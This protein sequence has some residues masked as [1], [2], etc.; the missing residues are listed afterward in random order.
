MKIKE[1]TPRTFRALTNRL[2]E[3]L[4]KEELP[5]A[6]CLVSR[7]GKVQY[8]NKIGW[9]DLE[10]KIPIEFNDIFQI[11]SMTKPIIAI[12]ILSL[13][14]EKKCTLDDPICNYLPEFSSMKI[15][16][17]VNKETG[18]LELI[19]NPIPITIKH[20]LTHT[21]GLSYG[22]YP[23]MVPV[24]KLYEDKF[25]SLGDNSLLALPD[26]ILGGKFGKNLADFSK[27]L[28]SL[29][30]IAESGKMWW[31]S[32]S[33]DLLGHLVE[34]I[35]GIP[36]D[37]FLKTRIFNKLGMIDT[38]FYVPSD[39]WSRL[40]KSYFNDE[41]EHLIES[42]GFLA[43]KK[44]PSFLCGGGGLFSTLEDYL[45]FC[46]MILNG[47]ELNGT[48]VVF[49][50]SINLMLSDHLPGGRRFNDIGPFGNPESEPYKL[51]AGFGFGLGGWVKL[52]ENMWKCG[53]GTYSWAGSQN[54]FFEID[55]RNH[56]INILMTQRVP[57]P[58]GIFRFKWIEYTN[59][60]YEG[61]NL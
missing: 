16:K 27:K 5:S 32:V 35:S 42:K 30:L 40:A 4:G 49:R 44:K 33:F 54:T 3:L 48:R 19:E 12:A 11:A 37:S 51:W 59:L 20:L 53:V 1:K 22:F 2:H 13:V 57:K 26:R 24:D 25:G 38:D 36:L 8:C 10:N 6:I 58:D 34:L 31:Y 28:S 29:P 23:K 45:K 60:V 7:K 52:D 46:T 39:K 61:L 47:G 15:L 50:D 43:F 18:E 41:G 55:R 14:E 21:S 9:K 56:V 17:S